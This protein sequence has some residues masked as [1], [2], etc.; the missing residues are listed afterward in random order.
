MTILIGKKTDPKTGAIKAVY[1]DKLILDGAS[2]YEVM[3]Q[4]LGTYFKDNMEENIGE[5]L[6]RLDFLES[7]FIDYTEC[8]DLWEKLVAEK[9]EERRLIA[10]ELKAEEL[11]AKKD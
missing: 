9:L 4:W 2:A 8:W 3:L 11:K 1:D 7:D 10:K 5:V 6:S